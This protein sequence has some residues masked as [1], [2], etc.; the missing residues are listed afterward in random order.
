MA[1]A[2]EETSRRREIQHAY[3]VRHGIVPQS[4]RKN[5]DQGFE[6][7]YKA[8]DEN[9][10]T[11]VREISTDYHESPDKLETAVAKLEKLMKQAAQDL[12]FEKAAELR[13]QIKT[14]KEKLVFDGR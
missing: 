4:V 10:K 6:G 5:I 13:D 8:G 7:L 12:E 3:N 14:I 9:K 2:M 1:K 11:G